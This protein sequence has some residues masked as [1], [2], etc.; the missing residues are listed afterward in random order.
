MSRGIGLYGSS[1][2][3]NQIVSGERKIGVMA[4][5][6]ERSLEVRRGGLGPPLQG[7][8]VAVA[9]SLAPSHHSKVPYQG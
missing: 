2:P 4:R 3:R 6:R 7:E 8:V 1:D 9:P 5:A